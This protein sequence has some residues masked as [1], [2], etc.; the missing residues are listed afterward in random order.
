MT[1]MIAS[2]N[3][4][5][6]LLSILIAIIA[7]YAML[8]LTERVRGKTPLPRDLWLIGGGLVMGIGVWSM[9]FVGMLAFEMEKPMSYDPLVV[10]ASLL[11][12]VIGAVPALLVISHPHV[13]RWRTVLGGLLMGSGISG[14][15]YV[16]MAAMR[17]Q[18]D[19]QYQPVLVLLSVAVAFAASYLAFWC[20]S[21]SRRN[22]GQL[23]RWTAVSAVVLGSGIAAMHYIG[24]AAATFTSHAPGLSVRMYGAMQ[25]S[26]LAYGIGICTIVLLG[27]VLVGA[28]VDRRYAIYLAKVSEQRYRSLFE[29]NSDAVCSFD[30]DG[31]FLECNPGT[32]EMLGYTCEELK[33]V[34]FEHFIHPEDL[35]GMNE[36]FRKAR[37]GVTQNRDTRVYNRDGQL[38]HVRVLHLPILVDGKVMGVYG[39]AHD[40]TE[41]MET[42]EWMRNSEKLSIIGQLAAGV[43]HEIRNPLTAIKG[44]LQLLE[45]EA[46]QNRDYY[47]VMQAELD[48][49]NE[50]VTEF[51]MLAKPQAVQFELHDPVQM[52]RQII[53]LLQSEA[54]MSNIRFCCDF[55]EGMPPIRCEENQIKQVFLNVLKNAMEAMPGGG[56]IRIVAESDG[57]DHVLVRIIDQGC[58]IPEER[59][60]KIGEPFYTTKEK[61]TG[62]GMMVSSKIIRHHHGKLRVSSKLQEGTTVD[63]L[64]PVG[65]TSQEKVV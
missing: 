41:R 26:L 14:M 54:N 57:P 30:L 28:F 52:L 10:F 35:P 55:E 63:I 8:D 36:C 50:I 39:I 32:E 27:V 60:E 21:R 23:N 53:T 48:R 34:T 31:Y 25:T 22:E 59:L 65:E 12:A 33:Q 43:A 7:A 61:G 3:V 2:Y 4:P 17:M 40:L 37:E 1:E 44:F 9:H 46:E 11:I 13:T 56:E 15:H 16:G 64:L 38:I 20:G 47:R 51:L 6:V 29:H 49:I 18:A 24:M 19:V 45:Q 42:E 62:L 5:L 58:G